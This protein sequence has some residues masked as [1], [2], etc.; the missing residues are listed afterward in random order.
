MSLHGLNND[1]SLVPNNSPSQLLNVALSVVYLFYNF[2]T[3]YWCV[4]TIKT[5][6]AIRKIVLAFVVIFIK[7]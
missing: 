7:I 3:P 1:F 4:F 2:F 6:L 5:K